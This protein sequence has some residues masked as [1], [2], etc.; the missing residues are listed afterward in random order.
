MTVEDPY[1]VQPP[2]KMR[3]VSFPSAVDGAPLAADALEYEVVFEPMDEPGKRTFPPELE[4]QQEELH[5]LSMEEPGLAVPQL[6]ELVRRYPDYSTLMNWLVVALKGAGRHFEADTI[7]ELLYERDPDYLF[8]RVGYADWC[9]G[10]GQLEKV[11]QVLGTHFDLRLLYPQR[12]R[13]H[14]TEFLAMSTA[15]ASYFIHLGRIKDAERH[16]ERMVEV[17]PDHVMTEQ[18]EKMLDLARLRTN[19]RKLLDEPARSGEGR[20]KKKGRDKRGQRR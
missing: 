12:T 13:F 15:A 11:P 2:I 4:G 10:N 7:T 14:Y 1:D 17:A 3:P 16:L 20:R 8:A 18:V 9:V 19:L 5:R 6:Q